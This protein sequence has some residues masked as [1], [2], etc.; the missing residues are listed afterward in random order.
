VGAEGNLPA[1]TANL[2]ESKSYLSRVVENLMQSDCIDPPIAPH[3]AREVMLDYTYKLPRETNQNNTDN[4]TD[5]LEVPPQ[6]R[7]SATKV[8]E[9][10]RFFWA[11]YPPK[12]NEQRAK[13]ERLKS[14]MDGQYEALRKQVDST[15]ANERHKLSLIANVLFQCL[16][17]ALVAYDDACTHK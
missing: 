10:L 13:L 15:P 2:Q 1:H 9:L 4:S 8:N 5:D 14:S 16:D 6:L 17:A 7:F 12:N 3:R 11:M